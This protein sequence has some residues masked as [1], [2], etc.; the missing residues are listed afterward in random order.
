MKQKQKSDVSVKAEKLNCC[1]I[2]HS[3]LGANKEGCRNLK[4]MGTEQPGDS[5]LCGSEHLRLR[6]VDWYPGGT[7]VVHNF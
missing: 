4:K 3:N 1:F 2:I 5:G 7:R 6:G